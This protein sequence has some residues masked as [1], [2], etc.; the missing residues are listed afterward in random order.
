[1]VERIEFEKVS[2]GPFLYFFKNYDNRTLVRKNF[3]LIMNGVEIM[4]KS[5]N[6]LS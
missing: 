4:S 1:M 6:L 3:Y 5:L 2:L